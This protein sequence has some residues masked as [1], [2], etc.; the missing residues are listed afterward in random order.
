M[1]DLREQ[2]QYARMR[3]G[4]LPADPMHAIIGPLE[5]REMTRNAVSDAPETVVP[6]AATIP[7]Y[8]AGKKL[9]ENARDYPAS[10]M[11]MPGG[12]PFILLLKSLGLYP[13]PSS[14]PA[15]LDEIFAGYQ[16]L[17]SGLKDRTVNQPKKEAGYA[18]A[19]SD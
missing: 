14:S 7:A 19:T 16:G 3:R 6:L 18:A 5:H 12:L 13:T 17:F 11:L 10:T 4:M 1:P 15:S 2:Y 9:G 8:S